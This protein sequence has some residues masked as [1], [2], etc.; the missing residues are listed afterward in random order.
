MGMSSCSE[1]TYLLESVQNFL[2][3]LFSTQGFL[4]W[5]DGWFGK[6]HKFWPN[7]K[8]VRTHTQKP[9]LKDLP[10]PVRCV[11]KKKYPLIVSLSS[12]FLPREWKFARTK[13]WISYFEAGSTLPPPFNIMPTT[14]SLI[15]LIK[16][17]GGRGKKLSDKYKGA[18][19]AVI[20]H[21]DIMHCIVKRFVLNYQSME[22]RSA[23][24]RKIE[25]ERRKQF[26]AKVTLHLPAKLSQPRIFI[27]GNLVLSFFLVTCTGWLGVLESVPVPPDNSHAF[28]PRPSVHFWLTFK[29]LQKYFFSIL[30][31]GRFSVAEHTCQLN[32]SSYVYKYVYSIYIQ[33][34]QPTN[35]PCSVFLFF[36]QLWHLIIPFH[37]PVHLTALSRVPTV[38]SFWVQPESQVRLKPGYSCCQQNNTVRTLPYQMEINSDISRLANS[39]E[40]YVAKIP[41][42]SCSSFRHFCL[43]CWR[44]SFTEAGNHKFCIPNTPLI[45][46]ISN[47]ENALALWKYQYMVW[48]SE[49]RQVVF[50][51][52]FFEKDNAAIMLLCTS[53][54]L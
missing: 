36:Q 11:S 17:M 8:D 45:S 21:Q 37:A 12:I 25:I 16:R 15:S 31:A 19:E 2:H 49:C 13:L 47:L 7:S 33:I 40:G 4:S 54:W 5:E 35:P 20:R 50:K 52:V 32:G 44:S 3:Q 43:L 48:T 24:S 34:I 27:V 53:V 38:G 41:P 30:N 23:H 6:L 46:S 39:G 18:G 28:T 14:K 10:N 42:A 1:W 29:N 9:P 51:Y 22:E 26:V